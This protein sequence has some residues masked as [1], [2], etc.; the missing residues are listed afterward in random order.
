[1]TIYF[2]LQWDD[3]VYDT[4]K[5][6]QGGK[7]T[8]GLLGFLD[9]LEK[10][11]GNVGAIAE[12]N[13]LR[14][15][16]YR[17]VLK[18]CLQKNDDVFYASS[19][20]ADELATAET[21]LK[22]RDELIL[23][24][25]DFTTLS[26]D[27]PKRLQDL[28]SAEIQT[29]ENISLGISDRFRRVIEQIPSSSLPF[30]K[31]IVHE[32]RHL[33]PSFLLNI[34]DLLH[35]KEIHI[36]H[37]SLKNITASND[38]SNFQ[39]RLAN[40]SNASKNK[41]KLQADGSIIILRAKRETE[42][43]AYLAKLLKINKNARPT[44]LIPDKNRTL[45]NAFIQEGMPSMGIL[46]ASLGRPSLQILKL[47]SVFLWRPLDPFKVLEFLSLPIKPIDHRLAHILARTMAQ[48]PGINGELWFVRVKEYFEKLEEKA[49]TDS[50]IDIHLIRQQYEMW[51]DRKS[52][53]YPISGYVP[54]SEARIIFEYIRNWAKKEFEYLGSKNT[55]LLTL[56]E[57]AK[58][59]VEILEELPETEQRL[60]YLQLER[61]VKTVYQ[62]SPILFR[63]TE[64]QHLPYFYQNSALKTETD[65]LL[66]WNFTDHERDYFFS[67]WYPK[68]LAFF[69]KNKWK[70]DS[71]S[72]LNRL[73][74][75]QRNIPILK[76]KHRLILVIP[77]KVNGSAVL[78]HSLEGDLKAT[79]GDLAPIT[80]EIGTEK[81]RSFLSQFYTL[82]SYENID[83]PQN[84][85]TAIMLSLGNE[86]E[87]SL[88]NYETY[89]SL[90]Q[91]LYYPHQWL[92]KYQL[93]L[94]S[95]SILSVVNEWTLKGN[96]AHRFFEKLLQEEVYEWD[97]NR[98]YEWIDQ[99]SPALLRSEGAVLLMYGKEPEKIAFLHQVK[100]AAWTLIRMIQTNHWRIVGTEIDLK[101]TFLGKEV[102]GKAD[103]VLQRREELCVV[104]L[105]WAGKKRREN[106][107]R[108]QE[109][110]QLVMYSK[111]LTQDDSW[112]NTAY[113][114]I[115]DAVMLSRNNLA[116]KEAQT[117]NPEDNH[118]LI[119]ESIWKR[120]ERTYLWR[121]EQIQKGIIEIRTDNTSATLDEMYAEELLDLLEM[122]D[123]SSAYD[124]YLNL[125]SL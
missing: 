23:A 24:G 81:G 90:D 15:E 51:F 106:M 80:Y 71:P 4:T 21:L 20:N 66:W 38:L 19:F 2:G 50:T 70:L 49:T 65:E 96:L 59:V 114:I 17:Q 73:A 79:F 58:K 3:I 85:K 113:F 33:L 102:K 28:Q 10:W 43:A 84:K 76:T 78:A 89:T 11:T 110:L 111:L 27:A 67:K 83:T 35:Q 87:L 112:A 109:D 5:E 68:E 121:Q 60:T 32:P 61:I 41:T 94:H 26:T 108:S 95:Q 91:L 9:L 7:Y 62:P 37:I 25:V 30:Q 93:D 88:R 120:M 119:H 52:N 64:V 55:S 98:V 105:K 92:F 123:S 14:I 116:F 46:S 77:E 13:L 22:M 122:K 16:Q 117:T 6:T 36:S 100:N 1:M 104:D 8:L 45:D 12:N 75:W 103:L 42:A 101:G 53:V 40:T 63:E 99:Q 34:F 57:Q 69:E 118:I 74:L 115:S 39:Y 29:N 44:C 18:E 107:I 82:P 72:Q 54:V 86:Q 56:S 125:I 124:D 48:S 47:I 97:K 31:I